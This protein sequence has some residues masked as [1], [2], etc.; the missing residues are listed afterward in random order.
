MKYSFSYNPETQEVSIQETTTSSDSNVQRQETKEGFLRHINLNLPNDSLDS[1]ELRWYNA[2]LETKESLEAEYPWLAGYRGIETQEVRPDTSDEILER[3]K[4]FCREFINKR[5]ETAITTG[6]VEYAGDTFDA[7][8]VAQ[9]NIDKTLTRLALGVEL[10]EGFTWR[11]T[12]NENIPFDDIDV[13]GLAEAMD[14]K[15]LM[16]YQ[17]SW[18]AKDSFDSMTTIP[19][20]LEVIENLTI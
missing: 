3:V 1:V 18:S 16:A 11:S 7:D 12:D 4:G 2:D 14:N 17:V 10:P 5:R 9:T 13:K 15:R 20:V 8:S 6:T 19:Q